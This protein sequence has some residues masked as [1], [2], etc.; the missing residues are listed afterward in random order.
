MS[1]L[2][3]GGNIVTADRTWRADVYCEDGVIKAVGANL[4]AP[5]GA[6]VVDAGGCYVMPGGIDPQTH[7]QLP[8][9]GTHA[10]DDFYTGTAAA[11]SG[12]TT[13]LIDFVIPSPQ[14]PLLEAFQTWQD[15]AA[16]SAMD[17]SFLVAV[18][19]WGD[20]VPKDM[21]VLARDHGVNSFKH[22]MAYKGAIMA[23]D[24]ILVASFE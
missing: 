7:M 1:V 8:F 9:M 22:F 23:D 20:S 21:E 18:T 13:M 16:K 19:W 5:A 6:D 3:R 11:L 10:I 15:W 12:G 17:Y 24:E 2:I 14:T 4:E